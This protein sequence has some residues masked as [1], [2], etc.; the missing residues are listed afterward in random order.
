MTSEIF[1]LEIGG[2]K[3]RISSLDAEQAMLSQT[4][5]DR[6]AGVAKLTD[7]MNILSE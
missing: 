2:Q 1:E 5:N 3:M 6:E 4:V 7:R